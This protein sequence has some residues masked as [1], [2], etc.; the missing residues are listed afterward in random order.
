MAL[1]SHI[2]AVNR[3]IYLSSDTINTT[4][5]PIDIYKEARALRRTDETLR[6]YDVFIKGAGNIPKGSGKFTERYAI[7]QEGTLIVP[8]DTSHTLTING[9]IITDDGKEGI[10]CFDRSGLSN[11]TTVDINYVPPQVEV[12]VIN[13]AN[14]GSGLTT[15][16]HNKLMDIPT[17]Q[18]NAD[19][20]FAEIVE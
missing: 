3:K 4:I 1:I 10:H 17:A 11:S 2:D 19:A 14:S 9:T 8:Y 13:T 18:E 15:N 16:E 6:P 5:N 20:V 7:L 12:I